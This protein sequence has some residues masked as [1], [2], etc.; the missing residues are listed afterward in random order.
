MKNTAIKSS[1]SAL[2]LVV[3]FVF[4]ACPLYADQV[5]VGTGGTSS[6]HSPG[7]SDSFAGNT[8]TTGGFTAATAKSTATNPSPYAGTQCRYNGGGGSVDVK[9]WIRLNPTLVPGSG[10][11]T[12]RVFGTRGSD[13]SAVTDSIFKINYT[14]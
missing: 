5:V 9:P 8:S 14:G 13:A 12:Y 1:L 4:A 2:S 11:T 3:L 10:A 6:D 7:Y